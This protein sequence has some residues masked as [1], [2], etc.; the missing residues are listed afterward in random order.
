MLKGGD[1][2]EFG[3]LLTY[4]ITIISVFF[5]YQ[6]THFFEFLFPLIS[7]LNYM[8]RFRV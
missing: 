4:Y 6:F 1:S 8:A 2:N 5:S 3:K 7:R